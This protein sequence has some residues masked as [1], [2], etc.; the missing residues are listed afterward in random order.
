MK[1][2]QQPPRAQPAQQTQSPQQT[3]TQLPT[4]TV[5][6]PT[7]TSSRSYPMH[8]AAFKGEHDKIVSLLLF[9]QG[10]APKTQGTNIPSSAA[11]SQ[12]TQQHLQQQ[13][14]TQLDIESKYEFSGVNSLDD[15]KTTPLHHASFNGHKSCV[16]MMLASGAYP[17]IQDNDGGTPLHNASFNGYWGIMM[18]LIEAGADINS[19]DVDLNTALHKAC[20][21][22]FHKCAELLIQH[23]ADIEARDCRGVTPLLKAIANQHLTCQQFLMEKGADINACDYSDATALHMA[24]YKGGEKGVRL[25]LEKGAQVNAVDKEGYTSLHNAVFNGY[26]E[27]ARLLLDHGAII[28][29]RSLDGCSPLHLAAANGYSQCVKLLIRRGCKLDQR[30]EK[31][32]RSALHLAAGKGN[33][34]CVDMLL[35]A[36][37]DPNAKDIYGKTP[38]NLAKNPE[39]ITLLTTY[40]ELKKRSKSKSAMKSSDTSESIYMMENNIVTGL[41][42][43]I[44][45]TSTKTPALS[46]SSSSEQQQQQQQQQPQTS[47]SHSTSNRSSKTS[48]GESDGMSN[49]T[50]AHSIVLK[51]EGVAISPPASSTSQSSPP[52]STN[53]SLSRTAS[54]DSLTASSASDVKDQDPAKLDIYGFVKTPNTTSTHADDFV[55]TKKTDQQE[56]KWAKM[57]KNWPKFAKSTKLRDRLPKGIPS[58]VRG[59]VWQRLVNIQEIKNK[60]KVT[61]RELLEMKAQPSVVAQIQRDISRT[62]PKHSFFIE[63]GGYGQQILSNILTAFS[64]YNPEVGYCQGMGFITCLLIIYMA[65]E[66]AF[67]VLVQLS[68]K[69][70]MSNMWRPE[71]P[72]LQNSFVLLNQ[73]LEGQFPQL[74]S[75]IQR[76]NVFTPLFSSQW[77]ICL[78]IYN[79]PFPMIVRIWDLFLYDGLVVIF[80]AALALF[81]TYEDQIMKLEFEEILNLLKFSNGEDKSPMKVDINAFMKLVVHYR[82]KIRHFVTEHQIP[83]PHTY[84]APASGGISKDKEKEKDKE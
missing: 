62:F 31:R 14:Q 78:L 83:D 1:Q 16:R 43:S 35:K 2:Q 21:S 13:H 17:D 41:P 51:E 11:T 12:K 23:G 26:E 44:S 80:A 28:D 61:Y 7:S 52:H 10:K 74:Y 4:N 54:F 42:V 9:T 46:N 29:H 5:T 67:W 69:Y 48:M 36:G 34:E 59:F 18:L 20:Y 68:E 82:N 76:Q 40:E 27:S 81:K 32:S 33:V 15:K 75:H 45:S 64:I 56:R 39:V 79:L 58:S 6:S 73:M 37:S 63:K 25:L 70:G 72:Y 50:P 53:G 57:T 49:L 47:I 19:R 22:G 8:E 71:F 24:A 55:R 65:E 60:S 3:Q 30:E 38:K 77:F 84:V 66:D